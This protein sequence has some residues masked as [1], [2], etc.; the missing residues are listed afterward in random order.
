[1]VMNAYQRKSILS[2]PSGIQH[3]TNNPIMEDNVE[4][5]PLTEEELKEKTKQNAKAVLK[6]AAGLMRILSAHMTTMILIMAMLRDPDPKKRAAAIKIL[7]VLQEKDRQRYLEKTSFE[8]TKMSKRTQ[9]ILKKAGYTSLV[10]VDKLSA[11]ELL[12]IPG[13]GYRRAEESADFGTKNGEVW[14]EVWVKDVKPNKTK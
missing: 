2:S 5:A 7:A 14:H 4:K 11:E 3:F 8:E 10:E 9:N 6:K 12:A 1:M 13:I